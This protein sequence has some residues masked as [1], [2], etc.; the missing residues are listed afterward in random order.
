[1]NFFLKNLK[2]IYIYYKKTNKIEYFL[3]LNHIPYL[4]Y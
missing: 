1:M 4:N 2:K 3:N